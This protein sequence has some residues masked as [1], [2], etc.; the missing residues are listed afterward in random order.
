MKY[1]KQFFIVLF[2]FIL[3]HL[4]IAQDGTMS[5]KEKIEDNDDPPFVIRKHLLFDSP[6]EGTKCP[7]T[8]CHPQELSLW[9]TLP[10]PL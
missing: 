2:S 8:L 4:N 10:N 1:L 7:S 5:T 3:F 9:E 6:Q